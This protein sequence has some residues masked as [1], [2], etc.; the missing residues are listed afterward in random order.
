MPD[1]KQAYQQDAD[2]YQ[3]LIARE[4]YQNNLLPAILNIA[5]P[6]NLNV[7]DL[8][9]GTGRL[10]C[11]LA[12]LVKSVFAFDLSPHMLEIAEVRLRNSAA[13]NWCAAAADHR[14]VPLASNSA[15]LVLSGWSFC[16]LVVW[17]DDNWKMALDTAFQEVDRVLREN[18]T[19]II[20]ETLGTGVE[21][22]EEP[23]KLARY[24][25]YLEEKGF[26]RTWIRTDYQFRDREEARAL[27]EFFF[28]EEMLEKIKSGNKPVL[29]ECTGLWWKKK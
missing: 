28:G 23:D 25:Q 1:H 16:Y 10:A 17:E 8:G 22:P 9:A 2:R 12:P 13:E 26:Q 3:N 5:N 27:V 6:D 24:Y 18:G 11:L 20:I 4:D 14:W 15:D 7:V 21:S 29:P 19:M